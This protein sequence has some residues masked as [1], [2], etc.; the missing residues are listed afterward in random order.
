MTTYKTNVEKV[1]DLLDAGKAV[2]IAEQSLGDVPLNPPAKPSDLRQEGAWILSMEYYNR[3]KIQAQQALSDAC[4]AYTRCLT[5][6]IGEQ[7]EGF[8]DD[9]VDEY[10]GRREP[11]GDD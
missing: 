1:L 4:D 6:I 3:W 7:F 2:R 11:M 9:H 8:V 10:H 5:D